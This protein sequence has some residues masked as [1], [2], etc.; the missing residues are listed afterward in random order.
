M[1]TC[2]SLSITTLDPVSPVLA[3]NYPA[4]W[5]PTRLLRS[6]W[7]AS[8][9]TINNAATTLRR[10]GLLCFYRDAFYRKKARTRCVHLVAR[11]YVLYA[12][13]RFVKKS[14][15]CKVCVHVANHLHTWNG[16][17]HVFRLNL[18]L[19]LQQHS[20]DK[21]IHYCTHISFI[22]L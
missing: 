20:D 16:N 14:Y 12:F 1:L 15:L 2:V 7:R 11:I 9:R 3:T 6:G 17:D 4:L 22:I 21:W 10:P 13:I 19:L 18:Y 5:R 8:R